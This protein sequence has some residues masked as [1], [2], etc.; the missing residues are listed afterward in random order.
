MIKN[1]IGFL[2]FITLFPSIITGCTIST[3]QAKIASET[4]DIIGK[5]IQEVI[6]IYGPELSSVMIQNRSSIDNA[7]IIFY[8]FPK[9]SVITKN[10]IVTSKIDKTEGME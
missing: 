3:E 4:T 10:G 7:E 8:E 9:F 6:K 2:L 5:T 1:F